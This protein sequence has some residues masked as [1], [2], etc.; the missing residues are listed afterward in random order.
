[1]IY[2]KKT[3]GIIEKL[4]NRLADDNKSMKWFYLKYIQKQT[5]DDKGY[6]DFLCHINW[7]EN[8]TPRIHAAVFQYMGADG[9]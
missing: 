7:D 8:V 9:I 6:R 4:K 1:M 2:K 5:T 3:V